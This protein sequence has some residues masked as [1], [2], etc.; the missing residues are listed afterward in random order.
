[1]FT[2]RHTTHK[3]SV[4]CACDCLCFSLKIGPKNDGS[5][6]VDDGKEKQKK[7][8]KK[9]LK[10]CPSS[11]GANNNE[12]NNNNGQMGIISFQVVF[13]DAQVRPFVRYPFYFGRS[14][15]LSV[16]LCVSTD[17]TSQLFGISIAAN[18]AYAIYTQQQLLL[19]LP[20]LLW[21][22]LLLSVKCTNW[23]VMNT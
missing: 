19:L 11:G 16:C 14:S 13:I 18:F 12:D 10:I 17:L 5:I 22:L 4:K 8:E 15:F 2:S 1:M 3:A 9:R 7:N 21:L 6:Q 20:P 23:V